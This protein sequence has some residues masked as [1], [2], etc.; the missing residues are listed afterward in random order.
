MTFPRDDFVSSAHEGARAQR[1]FRDSER[2]SAQ[3]DRQRHRE[4]CDSPRRGIAATDMTA[5]PIFGAASGAETL[6]QRLWLGGATKQGARFARVDDLRPAGPP[7]RIEITAA[8]PQGHPLA[9]SSPCTGGR[10]DSIQDCE[11]NFWKFG[12][13]ERPRPVA[14]GDFVKDLLGNVPCGEVAR[15]VVGKTCVSDSLEMPV[16]LVVTKSCPFKMERMIRPNASGDHLQH[17]GYKAVG[18]SENVGKPYIF[19]LFNLPSNF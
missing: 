7:R 1:P 6:E 13:C 4:N 16:T 18:R 8:G 14:C 17:A 19:R 11:K 3:I 12:D 9:C 15:A 10:L 5:P 2:D